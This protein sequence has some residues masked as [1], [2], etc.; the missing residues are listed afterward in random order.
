RPAPVVERRYRGHC[1]TLETTWAIGESRLTLTETMIAEVS[2]RLLPSLLLVR[3][4]SVV[5]AAA[6]ATVEFDPRLGEDHQPPR[7]SRRPADIV[8]EWGSLAM[9]LTSQP[10]LG[11]MPGE[12]LSV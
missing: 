9:S 11:I 6:E 5:G 4:L 10:D 7:V 12:P 1:A 8:C 3:R 2:G